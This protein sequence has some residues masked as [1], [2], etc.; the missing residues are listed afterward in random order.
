M[1]SVGEIMNIDSGRQERA[2]QCKTELV[3]IF[4][5]IK[6]ETLPGKGSA[7]EM[8]YVIFKLKVTS[9]TGTPH[10]VLIR[11][12]ADQ[13]NTNWFERGVQI[14]CDCADFKYR[15]A[16]GLGREGSLFVNDRI[17]IA[18][19]EA[20]VDAPKG[21]T[22]TTLLCKHSWAALRW[23]QDNYNTITRTI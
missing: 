15:S 22:K 12:S 11:V 6:R 2:S 1:Y 9:G 16:Y 4:H 20:L 10:T 19:G 17:K 3:K 5:E 14:Y 23:F 21:K 18:L 13:G 8:Y 7:F